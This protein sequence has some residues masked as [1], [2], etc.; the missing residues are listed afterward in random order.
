MSFGKFFCVSQYQD[1]TLSS[2]PVEIGQAVIES[3]PIL[4]E[5]GWKVQGFG[6]ASEQ[7]VF[8]ARA[9]EVELEDIEA[10]GFGGGDDFIGIDGRLKDAGT[11]AVGEEL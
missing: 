9:R 6:A 1:Q 3:V 8:A 10:D 11:L 5:V 2:E 7:A 4:A